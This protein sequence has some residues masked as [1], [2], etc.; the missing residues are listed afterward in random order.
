MALALHEQASL[1]SVRRWRLLLPRAWLLLAL[2]ILVSVVMACGGGGAELPPAAGLT[3]NVAAGTA[4]LACSQE[5]ADRG[6]CGPT[7]D[8]GPAVLLNLEQPAVVAAEHD[9]AVPEGTTVEVREVQSRTVVDAS[10]NGF[11]LN[12]YRVFVQSRNV[13]AWVAEWCVINV[14]Q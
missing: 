6:Q 9:L 7:E 8:R 12:F 4:A 2:V 14:P 13:E 11:P 1:Y 10:G 3:P 5:C